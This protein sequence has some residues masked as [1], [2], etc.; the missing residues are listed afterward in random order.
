MWKIIPTKNEVDSEIFTRFTLSQQNK[1]IMI[2]I[3]KFVLNI[4]NWNAP[5]D[6]RNRDKNNEIKL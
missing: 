5:H 1:V 4:W 6:Y 2:E 3:N